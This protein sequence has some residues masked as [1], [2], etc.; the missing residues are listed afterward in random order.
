MPKPLGCVLRY[1][2]LNIV[3]KYYTRAQGVDDKYD[4]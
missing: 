2:L 4:R 3:D 1:K